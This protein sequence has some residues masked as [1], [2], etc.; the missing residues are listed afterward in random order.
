M[1]EYAVIIAGIATICFLAA[2]FLGAAIKGRIDGA[3]SPNPVMP[4]SVF[5]PPATPAPPAS[6]P[7][8]LDECKRDG[9]R[10]F[11]QF[12]TERECQDYVRSLGR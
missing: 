4:P 11:P 7:S 6:E 1:A 5:T 12:R 3:D 10:N 9:W 8:S 2:L